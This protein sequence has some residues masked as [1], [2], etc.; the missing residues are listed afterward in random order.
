MDIKDLNRISIKS[1]LANRGIHPV[2]DRGYYGM[3]HSL[4][5]EDRNASMKVD[6][7]KNLWIDF[8][9]NE[10]GTMIDL[11]MRINN[12]SLRQ[13]I[14]ELKRYNST[15]VNQHNSTTVQQQNSFSFQGISVLSVSS[16]SN[17]SLLDYLKKRCISIDIAKEH[18]KEVHYSV[19]YKPYFAIGFRNDSAGWVLRSEPFKGC[20]SMD[21][22]TLR[23][24]PDNQACL[25]FEG[26]MDY[27]SYLTLKNI[28]SA[29][30][31]VVILNSVI[32]M[33]KTVEFI[34]QHP[35]IYTYLDNDDSGRKAT[36]EIKKLCETV[37]DRSANYIPCK[38]LNEYLVSI[39]NA[40]QQK[41][42]IRQQPIQRKPSRGFRM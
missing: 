38:D 31:D 36:E 5:R 16:L 37:Y 29:K 19:N 30:Q 7:N 24:D 33:P 1:Y 42:E 22:R 27:L 13:A 23:N 6:Y 32:N 4:F 35:A 9:S 26:F 39:K 3:Y 8:G 10:G 17:L 2:K 18:C 40:Q 15:S 41:Q 12:C 25:V 11:V 20:T 14:D 34:K 28:Q 21:I